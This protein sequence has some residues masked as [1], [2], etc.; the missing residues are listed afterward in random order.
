MGSPVATDFRSCQQNAERT[1][2]PPLADHATV[3]PPAR[4]QPP[5]RA[6]AATAE[7]RGAAG[8]AGA[9]GCPPGLPG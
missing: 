8:A 7:Q 6:A 4:R 9:A 3:F 2:P 1:R 5:A